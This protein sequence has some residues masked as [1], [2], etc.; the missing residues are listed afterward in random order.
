MAAATRRGFLQTAV[1]ASSLASAQTPD[2]WQKGRNPVAIGDL[3]NGKQL[4][5]RVRLTAPGTITIGGGG[6][7][8]FLKMEP[9]ATGGLLVSFRT[10]AN[11]KPLTL[12]VPPAGLLPAGM[13]EVVFRYQGPKADLFVD[14][15][16]VDEE[17]P[18]GALPVSRDA[19]VQASGEGVESV[20]VRPT[21]A[22]GGMDETK[23]E[24]RATAIFG[25]Q[26]PVR[27]YWRPRGQNTSAGDAMP[28]F[29]D[30]RFHVYYLFDRRHHGSKWGLGAHQW[31]HIS[32]TDLRQWEQHPM[33]LS[34]TEEWEASICT[35]SVF[36]EDGVWY[37]FYATRM[38]DRSERLG[39]ATSRDGILFE[40]QVPTPFAEPVSPYRRGPN[41]DPF[42]FK[43]G[44]GAYQMLVTAEL[45]RAGAA[46]RGGALELLT[47]PDLRTWTPQAPFLVPG[48]PGQPECSDL[49]AWNGWHYLLFAPD[50]ATRY[51]MARS[52]GGPWVAPAYD[53]L[54]SPES[55]VMKTAAFTGNRRIGVSFATEAGWGGDLV[56]RELLQRPDGTLG[57]RTPPELELHGVP[58]PWKAEGFGAVI[59]VDTRGGF[60]YAAIAPVP[61]DARIRV[62]MRPSPGVLQFGLIVRGKGQADTG[63]ELRLDPG[64]RLVEWRPADARPFQQNPLAAIEAVDGLGGAV[65]LDVVMCG[66]IF[67]AGING[68]RTLIHRAPAKAG[69]RLFV[70]AQ[71]GRL[72]ADQIVIDEIRGA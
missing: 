32:S 72:T 22:R 21:G 49:F 50:G 28:F 37:A 66:D 42:V 19:V 26:R 58:V 33:A 71:G 40:K 47:S 54:D 18:T 24:E 35:G 63:M 44:P 10:D 57:T 34:I 38:P 59:D 52:A 15:V 60:G 6:Q 3:G 9:A 29:H 11:P 5:V 39:M 51:R 7:E 36:H 1:A 67:D 14:G 64:R 68:D 20:S 43:K 8:P 4:T 30:G 27:Q 31:A 62:R 56:F 69:D 23:A 61:A 48:Y 46:R 65:L 12:S 2:T 13:H 55:R 53:L 45:E 70:W 41:R 17:W 16:L 25:A